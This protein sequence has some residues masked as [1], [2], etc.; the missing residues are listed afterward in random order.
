MEYKTASILRIYTG[1]DVLCDDKPLYKCILN[2][3]LEMGM[4]GATV[5]KGMA[6]F[7][8]Q[9]RGMGKSISSFISGNS[10]MP[11]II[12]IVDHR[13]NL[14]KL[15]PFLEK[16]SRHTFITIEDCTYLVTDY[17]KDRERKYRCQ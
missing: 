5:V 11:I 1:E 8:T 4:S 7:S 9:K 15:F 6:G 14:E 2:L 13:E 10:S 16:N 3:A 12:E 17:I